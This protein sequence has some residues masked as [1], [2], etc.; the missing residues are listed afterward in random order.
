MPTFQITT[1]QMNA[2]DK[3]SLKEFRN[4]M[5]AELRD[6]AYDTFIDKTDE[7]VLAYIDGGIE[8]AQK[9]YG[10][11]EEYAYAMFIFAMTLMGQDFDDPKGKYPWV[12]SALNDQTFPDKNN[13]IENMLAICTLN[14]DAAQATDDTREATN[15]TREDHG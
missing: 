11:T 1:E 6:L 4:S 9:K 12:A 3:A 2:F 15:N 14:S 8:R 13:R 10:A 5:L 7:E